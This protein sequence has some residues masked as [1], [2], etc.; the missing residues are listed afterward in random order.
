MEAVSSAT[1][2]WFAGR[3]PDG[4]FTGAPE[5]TYDRDESVTAALSAA[6]DLRVV[7]DDVQLAMRET[8]LGRAIF[9]ETLPADY[10]YYEGVADK[11]SISRIVNDL[12]ERYPRTWSFAVDGLVGATPELLVRRDHGLVLSR[13]LAGTIQRTGDDSKDLALAASLA[14]A[15]HKSA[16]GI[17]LP[18]K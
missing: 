6:C 9:N 15:S 5:V 11:S 13:V 10:P 14:R 16:A 2:G 17:A 1:V 3:L 7:A 12:A 4:W 18:N 8:S